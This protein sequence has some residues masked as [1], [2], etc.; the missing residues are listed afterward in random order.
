MCQIILGVSSSLLLIIKNW[1][2]PDFQ[3]PS[4]TRNLLMSILLYLKMA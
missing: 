4:V 2:D 3:L 1:Q